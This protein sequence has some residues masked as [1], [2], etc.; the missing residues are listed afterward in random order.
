MRRFTLIRTALTAL[1]TG[2]VVA[3]SSGMIAHAAP[4]MSH[5]ATLIAGTSTAEV[6]V[7]SGATS[8]GKQMSV[9]ILNDR[10]NLNAPLGADI[11]YLGEVG[12]GAGGTSTL[13]VVLPK[14]TLDGFAIAVNAGEGRYLAPLNPFGSLPEPGETPGTGG[15]TPGTGGGNPGTGGENPGSGGENPGTGAGPGSGTSP[16]AGGGGGRA[17]GGGGAPSTGAA[18]PSQKTKQPSAAVGESKGG[19]AEVPEGDS[20]DSQDEKQ[21]TTPTTPTSPKT[22]DSS[23]D[24]AETATGSEQAGTGIV[25]PWFAVGGVLFAAVAALAYLLFVRRR[26]SSET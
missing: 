25:W 23:A 3:L 21:T 19:S 12:V 13:R 10:A 20:A 1:L 16:G 18:K 17:P 7:H 8:T 11:V 2:A 26:S 22:D 9:L 24:D 4:A 5:D 15:E 6:T 14:A